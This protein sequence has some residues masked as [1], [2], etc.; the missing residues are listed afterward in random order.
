MSSVFS[1]PFD[2][3]PNGQTV[4]SDNTVFSNI[5]IGSG[6]I[7]EGTSDGLKNNAA[8]VATST[9]GV[10]ARANLP[11]RSTYYIRFYIKLSSYP[12]GHMGI[13]AAR[14]DTTVNAGLQISPAGNV[15]LRDGLILQATSTNVLPLNQ[16]V[17]LEWKWDASANTQSV[18][19][20]TGANL[21]AP[22]GT[23]DEEITAQATNAPS[24]NMTIGVLDGVA[25]DEVVFDEY[26]IDN[27]DWVGPAEMSTAS[28]LNYATG[29]NW[30]A[31]TAR[32]ASGG[33]W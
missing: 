4:T 7:F 13:A 3:V 29:G 17:R 11:T 22:A 6:A 20:F 2:T 5:F 16:W 8:R 18:R 30:Q 28:W 10:T 15:R 23:Y 19:I 14:N 12:S 27:S 26:A 24:D 9:A 25:V 33:S 31:A 32:N 1:E 21:H